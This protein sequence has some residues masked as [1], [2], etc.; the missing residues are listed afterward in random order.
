MAAATRYKHRPPDYERDI[1][2]N[3]SSRNGASVKAIQ[4]H[5]TE[6]L[7]RM[8]TDD[9]LDGVGSWFDN[10]KSFASSWIGVDGDANSRLWVP[11]A[12][13][14]WTMGHY[15]VNAETLNIEFV[16]RASQSRKEWE[17]KQLKHG[18][19]WAAYAIINYDFVVIDPDNIRRAR[20][21][22]PNI[23]TYGI[24]EHRDL[25]RQG[26]GTHTDPGD[27]FP[28]PHFIELIEYYVKNGW[29]LKTK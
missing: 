15:Q 14:A 13:K 25:T 5:T 2:G 21:R 10:P 22:G 12:E 1:V 23:T 20:F 27:N 29:T 7:D 17:E 4:V 19:K 8:G 28:M 11:G 24:G 3:R 6:S 16:G 9:D 26:I 18:A